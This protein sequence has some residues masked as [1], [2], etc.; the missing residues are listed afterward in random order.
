MLSFLG[1]LKKQGTDQSWDMAEY[2]HTSVASTFKRPTLEKNP[3]IEFIEK[4][5]GIKYAVL[6]D[7]FQTT[8][9][10]GIQ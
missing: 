5:A 10:R 1:D 3:I 9:A 7:V 8:S 4:E 6:K 2:V